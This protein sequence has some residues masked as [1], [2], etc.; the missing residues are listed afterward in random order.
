MYL[1]AASASGQANG[2][3]QIH[4]IDVGQEDGAVLI[5]PAGQVVL[6]ECR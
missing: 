4:H 3:L 2:K 6:F 5:S 1:L